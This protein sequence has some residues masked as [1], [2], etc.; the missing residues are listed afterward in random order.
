[1]LQWRTPDDSVNMLVGFLTNYALNFSTTEEV[2]IRFL[3]QDQ[4]QSGVS[5]LFPTVHDENF[6]CVEK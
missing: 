3:C 6:T 4:T 1:M 5:Y 2:Y